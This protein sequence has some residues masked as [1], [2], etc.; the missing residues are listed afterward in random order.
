MIDII[1][2]LEVYVDL[3]LKFGAC[4][5]SLPVKFP[6]VVGGFSVVDC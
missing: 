4:V 6:G 1:K 3:E 5:V 2:Y